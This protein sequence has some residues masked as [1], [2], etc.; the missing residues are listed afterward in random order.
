MIH[1]LKVYDQHSLPVENNILPEIVRKV[2][3]RRKPN[4]PKFSRVPLPL[5]SE[6]T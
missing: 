5:K 4:L 2:K 3:L 1:D 6:L